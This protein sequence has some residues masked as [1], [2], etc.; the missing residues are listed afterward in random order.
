MSTAI[1]TG[2]SRGLGL[3]LARALA[4]R[5]WKL[6]I[7][8]RGAPALA[9]A[10]AE[11]E[12]HT[13]VTA[14]PGDVTDDWH[15]AALVEAAGP[16]IDLLINNASTLGPSPQPELAHYPTAELARV[17]AVNLHAPLALIQQ[18]LPRLSAGAA[19]INVTSDAAREPYEGWG[20]YGSSKAALEQLTAI[21]GAE[22][23]ALR[24]Y[25]IDPGD[26]RTQMHQEAFPGQDISDR[27][28]PEASAP[29]FLA[30]IE[31]DLPSGRYRAVDLIPSGVSG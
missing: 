23:P 11:L 27:P 9:N 6:V 15:R 3:A 10:A 1:I 14:L 28:L 4:E 18:A 21:L 16:E 13:E 31:G 29:G 12:P 24:V 25:A 26:M 7:A 20:G 2:A 17:F 8:A 30:V 22:H 5:G 19:V